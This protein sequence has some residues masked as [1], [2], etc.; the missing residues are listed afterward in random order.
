[1]RTPLDFS[2]SQCEK[3]AIVGLSVSL[4]YLVETDCFG[5][6]KEGVVG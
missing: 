3:L 2:L 5:A 4:F 6:I 1:M